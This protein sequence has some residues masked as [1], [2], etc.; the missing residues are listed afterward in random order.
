[1]GLDEAADLIGAAAGRT[2]CEATLDSLDIA[3]ASL[4]RHMAAHD[5]IHSAQSARRLSGRST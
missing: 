4:V 2:V 3:I 1:M 5:A